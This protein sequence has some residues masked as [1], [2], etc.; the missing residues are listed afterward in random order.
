VTEAAQM[1]FL[2]IGEFHGRGSR[3]GRAVYSENPCGINLEPPRRK[4]AMSV[5]H[6]MIFL[7]IFLA[8][9]RLGG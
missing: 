7:V 2:L 4:T 3:T 5:L 1:A 6:Q 9:L 8:T